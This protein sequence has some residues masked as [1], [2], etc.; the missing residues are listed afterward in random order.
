M[1]FSFPAVN[2]FLLIARV[3][4]SHSLHLTA[5]CAACRLFDM[6]LH[7]MLQQLRHT[8]TGHL[9]H[10]ASVVIAF[11]IMQHPLAPKEVDMIV[12]AF[13]RDS[14]AS[15]HQEVSAPA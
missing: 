15:G 7:A 10:L 13:C 14:S 11:G 9:H 5:F 8:A 6:V 1:L 3:R 12:E 2:F 4:S